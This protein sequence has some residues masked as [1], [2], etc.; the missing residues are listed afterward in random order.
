MAQK[1]NIIDQLKYY[2]TLQL[3]A[4]HHHNQTLYEDLEKKILELEKKL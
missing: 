1:Q 4:Y 3:E 2:L